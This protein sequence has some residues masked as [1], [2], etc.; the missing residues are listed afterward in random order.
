MS[1]G[2]ALTNARASLQTTARQ[3]DISGR[4]I[5]GAG[6]PNYSRKVA[7]TSQLANG[8]PS[9]VL[10]TRAVDTGLIQRVLASNSSTSAQQAVLDAVDR[11]HET[12]GD[13]DSGTSPAATILALASALQ[14]QANSPA[15]RSLGP[16]TVAAAEALVT[17]LTNAT[18]TVMATRIDADVGMATSVGRINDILGQLEPLNASIV[19]GTFS[20]QDVTGLLD[21]RDSLIAQLSEEIGVSTVHRADNGVAIFTESGVPLFETTARVVAFEASPALAP[22]VTGNTVYIDGVPVTGANATMPIRTGNLAGLASFRDEIAPAYQ[23]QL[24]E[25]ARGLIEAFA[26]SDQSGGGGPDLAGLFTYAG[27]PTLPATGTLLS[28]LAA[29]IRV[30]PAVIPAQGGSFDRV[31]DGGINGASYLYNATA[32]ASYPDRLEQMID[33]IGAARVFDAASALE[34]G[35]SLGDFGTASVSWLEDLRQTTSVALEY[36]NTLLTRATDALSSASGVNMDDEY[37][38]QLQLEQS[39][40]ASSKL[41]GIIKQLYDTLLGA[42]E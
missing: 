19:N 11:L 33:E 42:V 17:S 6:D 7:H 1:L 36:Q 21:Q 37:A 26:E 2:V 3:I 15:D 27:G 29:S 22:G 18:E 41:I 40:A 5:A 30:N 10:V 34:S 28:G 16:A 9:V 14:T 32:A 12:I 31:R 35:V 8:S 24:D 13:T 4:N 38:K 39:Y 23:A 20:G 25:M